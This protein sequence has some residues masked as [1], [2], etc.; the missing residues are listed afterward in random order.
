LKEKIKNIVLFLCANLAR[1]VIAFTF[2]FSG[3]VK[4]LDPMGMF[5]K[6]NAYFAHWDMAFPADSVLLRGGVIALATI[7]FV[8]GVYWLL[9][10]RLRV[11]F[12]LTTAFMVM[13][14]LLT[15][16]VYVENP[17]SDCGCFG[18][19][20][21]L[22]NEETLLKNL[23]LLLLCIFAFFQR[24]RMKRLISERAQWITSLYAFF[25]IICLG[26]YTLHY[27]PI[28]DFTDYKE[29]T[30]WKA[31]VSGKVSANAPE[32]LSTIWFSNIKTGED[33]T[34]KMLSDG[35]TYLLVLPDIS[36]ADP[37]NADVFND[38][39]DWSEKLKYRF[40]CA[41][42]DGASED[43]VE[44][45]VDQT[46]AIYPILISDEVALKGMARSNPSL[47]MLKDGVLLKKWNNNNL[48]EFNE[49]NILD[50]KSFV[51]E[52]PISSF[53]DIVFLFFVPLFGVS[54]I[55]RIWVGS[56]YYK[57]YIRQKRLKKV[58]NMRKKIVAGNWKMNLNLQDGVALAKEL[59]GLL[60]ADKPACDVVICTPFIHLA[61]VAGEL[62]ANVLGLG[63]ENCADKV[64]GAYTGEVSAEM[65]KSTG[66]QY[67]ILGHSERRAYYGETAE[68]LKEKT[69][70]ALAN[71]LK[72]IFCI[73]EVLEE[74]ENGTQ[75][76]VVKA[77]LEGSL[78]DLTAEQFA[79]VILAYE[80][81]WAIGT[82]KTATAEQAQE[83]HAFIRGVIAEKF[84][85]EAAENVS[86]L[87]GG[88][89]KP[90]NA[91][92]IFAKPDVDGGLIGG[93]ALKAEDFK[94]IIDAWK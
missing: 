77:Q 69:N 11:T 53:G 44:G 51:S 74:R 16:Y 4:A 64:S 29:G 1:L 31:A 68:I 27:Q 79:N 90:S 41:V 19:V 17:V 55:D 39:Y 3:F 25:Y 87:Y 10:S 82:G 35:L 2:I 23:V 45:W 59:N 78:F 24:R 86:I 13:M 67:V 33:Q 14:T 81:V 49:T 15:V 30:D 8:L 80:P 57:N 38:L 70:L 34:E 89:C 5:Y 63:A 43:D 61:S 12:T 37:G 28:I 18:E 93:A 85:A 50:F 62:D 54:L 83:M 73:G 72:V 20:I 36:T 84:G 42:G 47:L 40:V 94:G 71:D 52:A 88:S 65:V 22:T 7:E 75:N 48:P 56:K 9:G 32:G 58:K 91:K 26:I 6:L 21:T 76:E 92:E 60:V 46:G 66:A